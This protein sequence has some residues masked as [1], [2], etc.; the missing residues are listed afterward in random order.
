MRII[1]RLGKWAIWVGYRLG[2]S[3]FWVTFSSI[4]FRLDSGEVRV[5]VTFGSTMFGSGT[6]LVQVKLESGLFRVVCS[7]L[8]RIDYGLSLIQSGWDLVQCLS[9]Y[10]VGCKSDQV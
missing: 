6:Y 5:W 7:S 1:I 4:M 2:F 8:D 3:S 10:Q 9:Q